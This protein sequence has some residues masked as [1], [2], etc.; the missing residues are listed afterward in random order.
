MDSDS[1]QS[2]QVQERPASAEFDTTALEEKIG[3]G[4]DAFNKGEDVIEAMEAVSKATPAETDDAGA[5]AGNDGS[6]TDAGD[7]TPAGT[8]GDAAADGESVEGEEADPDSESGSGSASPAK[9]S[10]TAPTLPD[11]IRRS[12]Y[13][14]GW[15]DKEINQ[16]LEVMG[17]EFIRTAQKLH[18][19]RTA[20]LASWAEMG[21][22]SQGEAAPEKKTAAESTAPDTLTPIDLKQLKDR[23]GDDEMF[24]AVIGPVNDVIA[25]LNTVLPKLQSGQ[26]TIESAEQIQLGQIV[27]DFF[28]SGD[29]KPYTELYGGKNPSPE[30]YAERTK[31]MAL[32]DAICY[33][34]TAQGRHI[35]VTDALLAAHDSVSAGLREKMAAKKI[36]ESVQTRANGVTLRPTGRKTRPNPSARPRSEAELES[37]VG[38]AMEKAFGVPNH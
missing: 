17:A 8:E 14:Y 5:D 4:L 36:K 33:G 1:T 34:A 13:A 18:A 31:V 11:S 10:P 2:Q 23:Y 16:N 6:E 3:A 12:L 35:S 9:G 15:A 19:N 7:E 22:R 30:Q 26:Q 28:S 20:E 21:R 37:K 27:S 38:A 29:V 32:A 24:D 25:R